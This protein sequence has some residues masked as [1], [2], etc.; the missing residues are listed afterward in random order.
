MR[1]KTLLWRLP[2]CPAYDVEGTE[3]W[4]T[5]MAAQGW[6]LEKGSFLLGVA[7][8]EKAKPA[9]VRYRLEAAPK[10]ASDWDNNEGNPDPEAVELN[11]DSGWEFVARRGQFYI[12]RS[13][14]GNSLELHTDP[15]VQALAI[16]TLQ[17]RQIGNLCTTMS[18][19]IIHSLL[20]FWKGFSLV[21]AAA[22][23]GLSIVLLTVLIPLWM[24]GSGIVQV[25]HLQKL[26]KK[27]KEGIPLDHRKDWRKGR[28]RFYGVRL[29]RILL[30][31]F[32]VVL[33]FHMWD[34][35]VTGSGKQE[36][37]DYQGIL[38]FTTMSDF[39]EGDYE[40]NWKDLRYDYVIEW[41][42]ALLNQGIKWAEHAA[43]HRPDGSVLQGG[44]HVIYYDAA[45]EW[46]AKALA[47]EYLRVERARARENYE[48]LKCPDFGLDE[49]VAYRN[50]VHFP[51]VVL[52]KGNR[53]LCAYFYQTGPDGELTFTEW[54]GI[55]AD[56]LA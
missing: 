9:A 54:A 30:I 6:M 36:R 38:P 31:A 11:A 10:H 13:E 34:K 33:V 47:F 51:C 12:Y 45:S 17:R 26:K 28:R 16:K 44:L 24:A 14:T 55:L 49:A 29:L 43:V 37:A 2:P 39:A 56:S 7:S 41:E 25:V 21:L 50:L 35:D 53:V 48:P 27:L 52:R 3:S 20:Y 40:E 8:F 15:Q 42:N 19:G 46:M 32:W 1:A 4:L 23:E 22:D 5:D 18:W